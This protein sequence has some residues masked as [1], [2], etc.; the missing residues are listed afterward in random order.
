MKRLLLSL[1]I[2]AF[3]LLSVPLA[4]AGSGDTL[5]IFVAA[6]QEPTAAVP[7]TLD[8]RNQHFVLDFDGSINE[9]AVFTA[10]MPQS[11]SDTTGVTVF[12]HFSM[13]SDTANDIDW[14]I[15]F[16]RI[17]DGIQDV[18]SDGFAT[19]LSIDGSSLP[20]PSGEVGVVSKAFAKGATEMDSI[21][22]GD[23][24]RIKITRDATNDTSTTDAEIHA[25]EIRET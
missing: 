18:D 20:S 14:D 9:N 6:N 17:G 11:Y 8:Q 16:E 12:I 2:A 5:L 25:V 15:A 24:F 21:I 4:Q 22:K 1:L 13:E 3:A 23:L 7:A 10:V 19:A